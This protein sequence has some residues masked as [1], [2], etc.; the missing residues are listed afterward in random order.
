MA[1]VLSDS[2]QI[3]CYD[4][5][6]NVIGCPAPGNPF[7]GQDASYSGAPA[8]FYFEKDAT[9][10]RVFDDNTG[11]V[12]Q[13]SDTHNNAGGYTWDEAVQYCRDLGLAAFEGHFGWRLPTPMELITLID[14]GTA[15]PAVDRTFFG[16]CKSGTYWTNTP[17]PETPDTEAWVVSFLYGGSNAYGDKGRKFYVRC[18]APDA[19]LP[20][21]GFAVST[22]N[23]RVFDLAT[24]LVWQRSPDG[25]KRNWEEALAYCEDL[26]I[27]NYEDWRLPNIRELLSIVDRDRRDPSFDPTFLGGSDLYYSSTSFIFNP[28]ESYYVWVVDFI[29]G[30]PTYVHKGINVDYLVRCVR[31]S[32]ETSSVAYVEKKGNCNGK[33]PCYT[34]I[35]AAIDA[36]DFV[37]VIRIAEGT[38]TESITLNTVKRMTLQGGWDTTFTSQTANTTILK[39]PKVSNGS[40]ILQMLCVRP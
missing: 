13:R 24:G 36:T 3:Y 28:I 11:L 19:P 23:A 7:S 29:Y 40:L 20:Y 16:T 38:Y 31:G 15:D 37:A 14:Y 6:G 4:E 8:G 10:K 32:D 9:D 1:Y 26:V 12:W 34:S 33:S 39:A 5:Y 35:Q 27:D 25:I 18:V 2:G 21:G 30:N 22:T 17:S